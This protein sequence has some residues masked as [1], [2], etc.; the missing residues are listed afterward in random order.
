MFKVKEDFETR[1]F[2]LMSVRMKLL[3]K[4]WKPEFSD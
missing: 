3:Q 4:P 2:I 1:G